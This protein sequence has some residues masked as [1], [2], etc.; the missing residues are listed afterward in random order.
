MGVT[1]LLIEVG[2]S[3][4][5]KK[6]VLTV[7]KPASHVP[8]VERSILPH[9]LKVQTETSLARKRES[10]ALGKEAGMLSWHRCF[11]S[12][13]V[14]NMDHRA[15]WEIPRGFSGVVEILC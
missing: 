6:L 5:Q 11:S 12:D 7:I 4:R 13:A 2:G 8:W 9:T 15:P 10:R 1:A 14:E 3:E